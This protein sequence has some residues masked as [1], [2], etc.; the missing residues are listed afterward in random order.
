[1]GRPVD[2]NA[3]PAKLEVRFRDGRQVHDFVFRTIERVL[4]IRV[5][6]RCL[7][8]PMRPPIWIPY[9]RRMTLQPTGILADKGAQ[10]AAQP[11]RHQQ[12]WNLAVRDVPVM[13]SANAPVVEA[14]ALP[15]TELVHDSLPPLGFAI[16]QLHGVYILSQ[17]KDG[18]ILV[19]M[20]AA[21]ERTTYER[22]KSALATGRV[23]TQPLLVPIAVTLPASDADLD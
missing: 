2:V 1:M 8:M 14:R 3:H 21:H 18:L 17:V 16:A 20:H 7:H 10:Q 6:A 12:G 19:D 13:N 9:C 15:A 22:L 4:R 11:V 23:P 5:P